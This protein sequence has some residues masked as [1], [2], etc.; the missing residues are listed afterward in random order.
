[1]LQLRDIVR[2]GLMTLFIVG[3]TLLL[4]QR[5]G[6]TDASE[7]S[8][9]E[10]VQKVILEV[11]N[12]HFTVGKKIPSVYLRVFSDGTAECHTEKYMGLETD[13]VKTRI[14]G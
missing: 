7:N 2:L 8:K 9:A 13:V 12:Y 11:M 3:S 10:R 14:L 1:M 5:E 6:M 4:A